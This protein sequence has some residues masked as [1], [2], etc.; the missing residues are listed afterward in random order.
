[1]RLTTTVTSRVRPQRPAAPRITAAR[2]G[3]RQIFAR[4]ARLKARQSP[5]PLRHASCFAMR[6]P[7]HRR[8]ETRSLFREALGRGQDSRPR[9]PDSQ[10]EE[11]D[12]GNVLGAPRAVDMLLGSIRESV[13]GAPWQ[14]A[15]RE[16]FLVMSSPATR[17]RTTAG[18]TRG[19][20]RVP[21]LAAGGRAPRPPRRA[22]TI[23][24]KARRKT[25]ED[26]IIDFTRR[27]CRLAR[28]PLNRLETPER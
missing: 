6:R 23:R 17:N 20:R 19:V 16:L 18:R 1:M 5:K 9:H 15:A 12:Y 24:A 28:S 8:F 2:P 11:S 27:D 25:I 3:I 21:S 14:V 10:S 4:S 22:G 13:G 26:I 7:G